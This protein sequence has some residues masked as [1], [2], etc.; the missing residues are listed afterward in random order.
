MPP[1]TILIK[2]ASSLC[3]LNCKY[4]FYYDVAE[5]REEENFGI[6]S[7]ETLEILVKRAFEYGDQYV[8][9]AFQ[10]GEPT[11]AGLDFYKKFTE[12]QEK[13]NTKRI[14]VG[15][16]IQTNGI[17]IDQGWA[18]FLAQ[19]HFL[20]GL[21]LDGPKDIHDFHR[22]DNTG[23]GSFTRIE[24]TVD[25]FN[26]HKV[27]YNILCVVTKNVAKHIG[28]IYNYYK[29]R[30]FKY[31]QFINCLDELGEEPGKNP[32]SLTPRDYEEFLK[33]LFDL[34]YKDFIQ[35]EMVSI[36]MFENIV[37]MLM[38]Y[39]PESCDM[40]GRCS[41]NVVVEAD[42]SVYPC[43]FYVLDQWKMGD[44]NTDSIGEMLKGNK[45]KDFVQCSVGIVEQCRGCEIYSI[46]RGGCR[47][48]Y[49]PMANTIDNSNYFCAAYKSFYQYS[50]P[51]FVQI[52]KILQSRRSMTQG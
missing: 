21:S 22:V 18:E 34:W 27:E 5:K 38:G 2:P 39:P 7:Y 49:E 45:A 15:N 8:G 47:R 52:A 28:K 6:M 43:D 41:A 3:N 46:C 50:L 51:K 40:Q 16:S 19:N 33:R 17:L 31:L 30:G 11:L 23:K 48:H 20:V 37:Q 44:I 35:G 4:C 25:L 13:Y 14:R 12:L 24:K 29:K 10:G 32:Y 9:F 42:G 26:K 36:R 1:I